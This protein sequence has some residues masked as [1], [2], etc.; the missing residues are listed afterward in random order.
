MGSSQKTTNN[1]CIL[2]EMGRRPQIIG[3][4]IGM[5]LGVSKGKT[6]RGCPKAMGRGRGENE[7][8]R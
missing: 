8:K 5:R 1:N 6:T 3:R 7:G 4:E 2:R